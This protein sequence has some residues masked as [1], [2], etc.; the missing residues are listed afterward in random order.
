MLIS[1]KTIVK[2]KLSKFN[3]SIL[4]S[5]FITVILSNP[6]IGYADSRAGSTGVGASVSPA[7]EQISLQPNQD[8]TNFTATITNNYSSPVVASLSSKDF[9]SF[10][11]TGGINFVTNKDQKA[12][13]NHGLA[14]N[15]LFGLNDVEIMPHSSQEVPIIVT[16]ALKLAPGGHYALIQY[17]INNISTLTPGNIHVKG[18]VST[19]LFVTTSVNGVQS[20]VLTKPILGSFMFSFPS[21]IN[22]VFTNYGNTQTSPYGT[23]EILTASSKVIS[24]AQINVGSGLILPGSSMLFEEKMSSTKYYLLPGFYQ[25]RLTYHTGLSNSVSVYRQTFFYFSYL[26]FVILIIIIYFLRRV[27]KNY[28]K[29]KRKALKIVANKTKINTPKKTKKTD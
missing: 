18:S 27:Y 8:T 1:L 9:S 28:N 25:L 29:R 21:T 19:V 6:V 20:L 23:I 16:N 12:I 4:L 5:L 22:L 11:S 3:I 13:H 26:H 15:I 17:S 2:K 14:D 10:T 24:R 7:I